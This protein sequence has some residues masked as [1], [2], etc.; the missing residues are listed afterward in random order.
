MGIGLLLAAAVMMVIWFRD[1][2]AAQQ[3][4]AASVDTLRTLMPDPQG[5]I[6]EERRDNTMP[7]LSL[8]GT[9]YIGILEMPAHGSELAVC[10]EWRKPSGCPC[11]FSGSVY[12]R[13]LQ[14]GGTSRQGQ[15]D[16]FREIS[17]GDALFFTDMTGNRYAYTVKDICY[18]QHADEAA[19]SSHD[20][21][22]TLFIK[23]VYAF[24][25]IL[26]FCDFSG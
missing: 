17:V 6:L 25:Y 1:I 11:R 5:A 15:Y 3:R 20:V 10:A 14:I 22:L 9:D 26:V 19:L 16:F 13:S 21:A 4:A 18:E 23:N 7:V 24:E 8:D 12:D 2:Y